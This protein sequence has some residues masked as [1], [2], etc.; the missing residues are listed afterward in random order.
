MKFLIDY[1]DNDTNF[2]MDKPKIKIYEVAEELFENETGYKYY[3][4]ELHSL[5]DLMK[6][7]EKVGFEL[8]I[9]DIFEYEK[10]VLKI[11]EKYGIEKK[12]IVYNNY[13]E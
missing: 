8:L 3:Y 13:L 11:T 1:V 10:E 12:I 7:Q 9:S 5:A 2:N 4:V 6:L